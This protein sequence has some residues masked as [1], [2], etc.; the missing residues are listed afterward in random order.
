MIEICTIGGYNEVGK[1][2]LVVKAGDEVVI[3]DMGLHLEPY[4]KYTEAED[5]SMSATA[6]IKIGAIPDISPI[7]KW[8]D[9]VVAI[10]PTHAH[11]DHVGPYL[12]NKFN[13][14]ILCTD[15]TAEVLQRICENAGKKL[16]NEVLKMN[17]N[18]IYKVSDTMTIEFIHMTHSTPQTVAVLLHTKYGKVLYVTDWKLDEHPTLGPKCNTKRLKQLGKQDVVCL[19]VDS[20]RA[21][22]EGRTPSE[23]K[24]REELREVLLN[25]DNRGKAVIVSTFS[26][27]LARLKSII[28]CGREMNRKITFFG[29]SLSRY[30]ES[31]EAAGLIEFSKEVTICKYRN[32]VRKR[33]KKINKELD[34]H[35]IV[36]TGHQ[37]EEKAVLSGIARGEFDIA[38]RAGDKIIF[39]C[40]VIPTKSNIIQR[41]A[42]EKQFKGKGLDIIK[43][44]HASGHPS[45]EDVRELIKM[46]KPANIIPCHAPPEFTESLI[47]LA[48]E[49]GYED[50]HIHQMSDGL[51]LKP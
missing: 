30:T 43:D 10:V 13:C 50:K 34:K 37:G 5:V 38:L 32:H 14:P 11:L 29:R 47:S 41:E 44:V 1:N 35:L 49:M 27:H 40:N 19:I 24:A 42:L 16:K 7:D 51:C 2:M 33:I 26:S 36:C 12:S 45:R 20:L 25:S 21:R 4:I 18:G 48:K 39:S 9:K 15:F 6:L 46:V 31:G 22:F 3:L 23:S 8:K 17:I 28:E